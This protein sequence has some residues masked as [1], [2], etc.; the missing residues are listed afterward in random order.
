MHRTNRTN[1][2]SG[3][4][5]ELMHPIFNKRKAARLA[6]LMACAGLCV[7]LA[8]CYTAGGKQVEKLGKIAAIHNGTVT[9]T[10]GAVVM[11][12]RGS[13]AP[14]QVDRWKCIVPQFDASKPIVLHE[15]FEDSGETVT[16][17][18][19]DVNVFAQQDQ[20]SLQLD[21]DQLRVGDLL[22]LGYACDGTLDTVLRL[23]WPQEEQTQQ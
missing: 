21:A 11:A 3:V 5:T 12:P 9:L 2:L 20:S 4:K 22:L 13:A 18:L 6:A 17:A 15:Q 1:G 10:I 19:S 23:Q 14:I 7:M 16:F 8:A